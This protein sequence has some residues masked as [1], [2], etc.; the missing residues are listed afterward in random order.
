MNAIN[1]MFQ[2]NLHNIQEQHKNSAANSEPLP[3]TPK[4]QF[5]NRLESQRRTKHSKA[6]NILSNYYLERRSFW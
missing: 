6:P 4:T 1:R 3:A 2:L 5:Q